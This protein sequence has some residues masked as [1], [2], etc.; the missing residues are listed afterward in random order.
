MSAIDH[1]ETGEVVDLAALPTDAR[2]DLYDALGREAGR[3]QAQRAEVAAACMA[4]ARGT[5]H[6]SLVVGERRQAWVERSGRGVRLRTEDR[7]RPVDQAAIDAAM[8]A[9]GMAPVE[10]ESCG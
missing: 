4:D 8:A 2:L 10:D 5:T 1:P 9:L 3:R 7:A 6:P